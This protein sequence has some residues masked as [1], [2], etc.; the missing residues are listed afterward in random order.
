MCDLHTKLVIPP[1]L[2][3]T[4]LRPDLLLY[5]VKTK[6]CNILELTC[7]CEENIEECHRKKFEKYNSLSKA[8]M[9]NGWETYLFPIEVGARGYCGTSV[10]SCFSRLGFSGKLLRSLLKSLSLS[11]IKTSFHIWQSRDSK[12]WDNSLLPSSNS[13]TINTQCCA[14]GI[15]TNYDQN[16]LP[17]HSKTRESTSTP[18]LRNVGILN[19]RQHL[20]H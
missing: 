6:I 8:V 19:K 4:R 20:L 18:L 13:C 15:S 16:S 3:V 9:L 7:C 17:T 10:K 11:S 2:A 5:S 14:P 1:F 12:E